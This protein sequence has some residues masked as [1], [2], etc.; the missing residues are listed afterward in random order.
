MNELAV[1]GMYAVV[2]GAGSGIGRALALR[3]ADEGA[4]LALAD[5]DQE[6]LDS[7]AAELDPAGVAV[8]AERLD[9]SSPADVDAFATRVFDQ[10]DGPVSMVFSNAGIHGLTNGLRPDLAVWDRV[11]DVNLRGTVH[12]GHAFMQRL[13]DQGTTAQFVITGSQ[14]SFLAA[15]GMAPYIATK[16][17]LWGY[18]DCL[19][20][21]LAA[22]DA[23]VGISLVAPS[24]VQSGMTRMQVERARES[25]GDAAAEAYQALMTDPDL[26]AEVMLREARRGAFWIIPSHESVDKAFQE[27]VDAVI[28][29]MPAGAIV[30]RPPSRF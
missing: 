2:T 24:R 29:A 13:L 26:V 27:R 1:R 19:R 18:A 23:P 5:V 4:H 7:V 15:P 21:E 6:S 17:A 12:M 9:V 28:E 14:A 22:V 16:H 30:R 25:G 3:L 10:A 20:I 11:I 8:I